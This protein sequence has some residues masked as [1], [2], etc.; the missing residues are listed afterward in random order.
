MH[1]NR[2]TSTRASRSST[3]YSSRLSRSSAVRYSCRT[4]HTHAGS[5]RSRLCRTNS[6]LKLIKSI[7]LEL[8]S[9]NLPEGDS[10][11]T[12][13]NLYLY[14]TCGVAGAY[15][16]LWVTRSQKKSL[17]SLKF[18]FFARKNWNFKKKFWNFSK[19]IWNFIFQIYFCSPSSSVRKLSADGWW[20]QTMSARSRDSRT[21][22]HRPKQLQRCSQQPQCY[23]E[24]DGHFEV[25]RSV[26]HT[27]GSGRVGHYGAR[28]GRASVMRLWR[29]CVWRV[30]VSDDYKWWCMM[31]VVTRARTLQ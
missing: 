17:K 8:R 10:T 9:V 20:T 23:W 5:W 18:H 16:V 21:H 19:I 11:C 15:L 26:W 14:C 29:V 22:T 6:D 1:V 28:L 31:Y 4:H 7:K 2:G 25:R 24:H 13:T 27:S 30:W 12:W 3:Y